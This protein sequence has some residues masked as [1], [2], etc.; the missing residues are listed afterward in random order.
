MNWDFCYSAPRSLT[1]SA[2]PVL[3]CPSPILIFTHTRACL[4]TARFSRLPVA[5]MKPHL[6]AGLWILASVSC[7]S[8]LLSP[9]HAST[10]LGLGKYSTMVIMIV[11]IKDIFPAV[12][13]SIQ[14]ASCE[15]DD[16]GGISGNGIFNTDVGLE[17]CFLV[18]T[19]Q[20]PV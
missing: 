11:M 16:F 7:I 12:R 15:T 17:V 10:V 4:F 5:F 3:V 20:W 13:L 6:R 8:D 19:R 9:S 14:C 18:G 1:Q 2:H